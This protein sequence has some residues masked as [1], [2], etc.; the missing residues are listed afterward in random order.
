MTTLKVKTDLRCGA[1]VRS[2][3]PLLDAEPGVARW[4]A[5]VSTPDR[6]LTVEGDGVTADRVGDTK[7]G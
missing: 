5:D 3:G 6:V 1:C 4:E 2:I 7:S